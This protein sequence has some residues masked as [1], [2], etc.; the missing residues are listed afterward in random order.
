MIMCVF[1]GKLGAAACEGRC[2]FFV[3]MYAC[4][5]IGAYVARMW[6]ITRNKKQYLC[7]VK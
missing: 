3:C 5:H 1:H 6:R 7:T 2:I 4:V